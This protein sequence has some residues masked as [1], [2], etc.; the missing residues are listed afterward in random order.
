MHRGSVTPDIGRG[1]EFCIDAPEAEFDYCRVCGRGLPA[2]QPTE[3][4]SRLAEAVEK[5]RQI[6]PVAFIEA[7][8]RG[9]NAR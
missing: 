6:D 5:A 8:N 7:Y 9:R 2:E 3:P 4:K 1:C